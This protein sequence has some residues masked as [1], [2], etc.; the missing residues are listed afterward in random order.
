MDKAKGPTE[1]SS[2]QCHA[3]LGS[4]S[5]GDPKAKYES[6]PM[7][8]KM[9]KNRINAL[10]EILPPF[11]FRNCIESVRMEEIGESWRFK[12]PSEKILAELSQNISQVNKRL[13]FLASSLPFAERR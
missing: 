5:P 1:C 9:Y 2:E 6:K 13:L 11:S 10:G 8:G 4:K 12:Q 7:P 3:Y